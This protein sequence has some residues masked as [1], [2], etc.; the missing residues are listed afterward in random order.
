MSAL[1]CVI[2]DLVGSRGLADRG[3][4]QRA[5]AA[6]LTEVTDSLR[7]VQDFEPTIGDELQGACASL[8]DALAA[9]LRV[10]LALRGVV[11][12]RWGVGY[13]E[14]EVHDPTR[15]PI[16]QDGPGWWAARAALESIAGPRTG[17]R[18]AFRGPEE[19]TVNAYLVCRDQLVDRLSDRGAE[20]ARLALGGLLQKDI[21]AR[22]GVSASAVSQQF[23]RGV[24]AVVS[25]QRLLSEAPERLPP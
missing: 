24:G 22:V 7:P 11:D 13:G 12:V 18:T 1:Y 25:S 15:R 4:A 5:V 14:V 6:A 8:A 2:G 17:R 20:I 19:T 23:A 9:T 10:R 21:A 16:L 3:T